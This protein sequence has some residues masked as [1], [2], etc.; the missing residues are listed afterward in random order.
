MLTNEQIRKKM[1]DNIRFA[2]MAAGLTRKELCERLNNEISE[3]TLI[4][5]EI[6]EISIPALK[7]SRIA[8]AFGIEIAALY[9]GVNDTDKVMD[10][11]IDELR[12]SKPA[13]AR[14]AHDI[15][16]GLANHIKGWL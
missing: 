7:V 13:E 15:V 10:M 11:W 2:R 5:Y 6:G 8:S 9:K 3:S 4:K 12:P 1:G 14:T 16:Q